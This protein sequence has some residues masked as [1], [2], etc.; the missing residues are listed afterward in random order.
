[1]L[2]GVLRVLCGVLLGWKRRKGS[3]VAAGGQWDNRGML[4]V[5]CS[6]SCDTW[7]VPMGVR[8]GLFCVSASQLFNG[9]VTMIPHDVCSV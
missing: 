7:G 6:A 2:R 4:R 3:L 1:M 5:L 9:Y 8:E